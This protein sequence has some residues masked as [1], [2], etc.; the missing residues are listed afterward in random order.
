MSQNTAEIRPL[1]SARVEQELAERFFEL[2]Q[3]HDRSVSGE[4]RYAMRSHLERELEL[5]ESA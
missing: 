4:L 5:E 1:V 3:R 2:A